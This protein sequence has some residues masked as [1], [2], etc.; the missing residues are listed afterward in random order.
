MKTRS[1]L[2]AVLSATLVFA[3]GAGTAYAITYTTLDDP[4]SPNG[5]IAA[6]ISGSN[7]VGWYFDTPG[8]LHGFVYNGSTYTEINDP[9]AGN[10]GTN[11]LGISGNNIVGTYTDSSNIAHGYFY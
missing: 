1:V 11:A 8:A 6:G 9:L 7:I 2:R 3:A 10:G 5:T 4:L